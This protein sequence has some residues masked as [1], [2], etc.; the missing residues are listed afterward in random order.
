LY[1]PSWQTVHAAA[2]AVEVD[3]LLHVWHTAALCCAVFGENVFATQFVQT[4]SS[5]S[6]SV[7]VPAP[8]SWQTPTLICRGCVENLPCAHR[9]N[10]DSTSSPSTNEYLPAAQDWQTVLLVAAIA[11]E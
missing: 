4:V 11:V 10:L 7:Y 9:R 6:S 1:L 5:A 8:Q 2:P 3:V